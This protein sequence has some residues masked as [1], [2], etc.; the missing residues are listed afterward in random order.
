[1][2]IRGVD[3]SLKYYFVDISFGLLLTLFLLLSC[4]FNSHFPS[5]CSLRIAM[6]A[7]VPILNCNTSDCIDASFVIGTRNLLFVLFYGFTVPNLVT[8]L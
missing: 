7:F 5:V 1:M 6:S 4:T 8:V 2:N 3:K